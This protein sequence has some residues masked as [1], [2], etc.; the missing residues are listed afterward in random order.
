VARFKVGGPKKRLPSRSDAAIKAQVETRA[1]SLDTREVRWRDVRAVWNRGQHV[2]LQGLAAIEA[3][4]PF[5]LKGV[6][7]DRRPGPGPS[8]GPGI[9]PG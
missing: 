6:G 8:R 4:P 3:I 5:T 7:S 9:R 1:E 2:I